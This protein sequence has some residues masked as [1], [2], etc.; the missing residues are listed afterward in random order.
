MVSRAPKAVP[1]VSTEAAHDLE[2]FAGLFRQL[3]DEGFEFAVVGGC[4]VVAYASLLGEDLFSAD[5]DLY[6]TQETL[7]ELLSWAPR[8]RLRIVKR[9]RPRNIPVAFLEDDEGHEIDVLTSSKGLPKPEIVIRTARRFTLT[10]HGGLEVPVA[11]PFD[12]LGNKLAVA[13]DKDR[14]HAEIL[15]RFVEEEAV[16]AFSEETE[17]R[18]R[19][20]P[21]R[22]LLGA[23]QRKAL[24]AELADRLLDL[25]RTPVDYRFLM[26]RVPTE[27]QARE[28]LKRME[29]REEELYRQLEAIFAT[30]RFDES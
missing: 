25:A 27:E 30:R 15:R 20:A 24:P 7:S 2:D 17:P 23:L 28:I 16:A 14:A 29:R 22:R 19:L 4:A 10:A 18:A 5:L 21:A 26:G 12:L 3:S 6:V 11:D 13:R 8:N 1:T 9:P